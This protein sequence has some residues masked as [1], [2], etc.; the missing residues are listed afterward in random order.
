MATLYDASLDAFKPHVWSYYSFLP[1]S[2]PDVRMESTLWFGSNYIAYHAPVH[3]Y[4]VKPLRFDYF[5]PMMMAWGGLRAVEEVLMI[6]D[7]SL[8]VGAAP[9]S[10]RIAGVEMKFGKQKAASAAGAPEYMALKSPSEEEQALVEGV[11]KAEMD[12][13]SGVAVREN[14][15]ETAFFYPRLMADTSGVVTLR[16]TLP[17][18]LTTWKFMA[19][20]HTKDMMAGLLTDEVVAAKEVMAQLS[21]PRF[22]R[23]GD[24][25]TLS[26]TLF[27]LTEKTLEG[28]ATMEVF[29]PATGEGLWKETVKVEMEAESDTVV[30]FA[31]TPSGT[32]S[33]PACRIIFEAGEHADGE[34]R[35]LP[36]L[37]DKEWLTQTQPFVVS[38]E[39]DTV[40][41]L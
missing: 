8:A 15:N 40:I 33:L 38:H 9:R 25:V 37:E 32:V 26:A 4:A 30:S 21:L 3:S 13:A 29:D 6:T 27:N 22:V 2:L 10:G 11:A 1:F 28:K 41:R 7:N 19:L 12:K 36:I 34:Q 31:Y 24:R 20:A 14:L 18:S 17:E 35:Y 23:M 16:F 39:G 5:N